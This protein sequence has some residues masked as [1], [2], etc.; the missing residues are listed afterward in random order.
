ML[1]L[2]LSSAPLTFANT[3]DITG[4]LTTTIAS[5]TGALSGVIVSASAATAGVIAAGTGTVAGIVTAGT[6]TLAGKL[7]DGT[8]IIGGTPATSLLTLTNTDYGLAKLVRSATPGNSLVVDSTGS[9]VSTGSTA[10][11]VDN[12]AVATAVWA[13]QLGVGNTAASTL[14]VQSGTGTSSDATNIAAI[15]AKT[16]LIKSGQI[17][18]VSP[19][20]Q[21][22]VLTVYIG[23]DHLSADGRNITFSDTGTTWPVFTSGS[24]TL[25]VK[26]KSD[27]ATLLTQT[28]TVTG[29]RAFSFDITASAA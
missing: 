6:E 23:R 7:T 19:V 27:D 18:M 2:T 20:S 28:G 29:A 10:V 3:A 26:R 13:K 9:V 12:A 4:S 15:K 17:S 16:D 5:S 21:T 1:A 14:L 24:C 25:T 8:L 22:G 11:T